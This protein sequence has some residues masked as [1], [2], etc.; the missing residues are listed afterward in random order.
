MGAGARPGVGV[1][2]DR[3]G[4]PAAPGRPRTPPGRPPAAP[5]PRRREPSPAIHRWGSGC[6]ASPVPSGR[7]RCFPQVEGDCP[8]IVTPPEVNPPGPSVRLDMSKTIRGYPG[9]PELSGCLLLSV[10]A[11]SI[12]LDVVGRQD[13]R[14][15]GGNPEDDPR[16]P[17][18]GA[19]GP[20]G[21]A[22]APGVPGG[23][24]RFTRHH[25]CVKRASSCFGQPYKTTH[26]LAASSPRHVRPAPGEHPRLL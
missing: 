9:C 5:R 7:L 13:G 17:F 21:S 4:A 25:D 22:K 19:G 6:G 10:P 15:T 8:G 20:G 26:L 23:L 3:A 16:G 12:G 11:F 18:P 14:R 2:A 24:T 1:T